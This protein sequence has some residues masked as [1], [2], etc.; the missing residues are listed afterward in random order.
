[1]AACVRAVPCDRPTLIERIS[2]I[3]V[4]WTRLGRR[5]EGEVGNRRVVVVSRTSRRVARRHRQQSA[6]V[7][8]RDV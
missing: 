4:G 5:T 7:G 1:V 6:S 3:T 2:A 8:R